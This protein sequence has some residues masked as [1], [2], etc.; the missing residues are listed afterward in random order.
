MSEISDKS[1]EKKFS[2]AK[3]NKSL[4]EVNCFEL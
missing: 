2:K 3:L 4:P 1:E